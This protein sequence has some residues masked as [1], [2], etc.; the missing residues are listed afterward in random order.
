MEQISNKICSCCKIGKSKDE[1]RK[2]KS[3]KDGLTA[4]CK[5]CLSEYYQKNKIKINLRR[6]ELNKIPERKSKISKNKKQYYKKNRKKILSKKSTI[7][8]TDDFR[9]SRRE[10]YQNN[11]E[12]F[13]TK[14]KKYRNKTETKNKKR[15]YHNKYYKE[16]IN[17]KLACSLR[18]RIRVALKNKIIK[19]N[20]KTLDV[21]GCTIPELKLHLESQ[22]KEGMSWDN[23]GQYG[24]HIDH[25]KPL[26][27]FDLTD[28]EQV[29][30]ACHY[31]NLQPLWAEENL[32]KGCKYIT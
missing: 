4:K 32:S 14:D 1:F 11:K 27:S 19:K 25:I 30:Q 16:N 8:K 18:S 3:E 23:H 6:K 2:D 7:Q 31:T 12:K 28:Q 26:S 13:K 5:Q 9:K 21:V 10:Y 22:F 24:W 17:Y 15:I 20:F 29:K